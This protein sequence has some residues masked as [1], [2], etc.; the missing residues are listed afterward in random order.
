MPFKSEGGVFL[1]KRKGEGAALF[2]FNFIKLRLLKGGR[3]AFALPASRVLHLFIKNS[4]RCYVRGSLRLREYSSP[5]NG[6]KGQG[7]LAVA[8]GIARWECREAWASYSYLPGAPGVGPARLC[9]LKK[10]KSRTYPC[11]I[12]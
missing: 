1:F 11:S 8:V 10:V 12:Y 7:R 5:A 2:G 4:S 6:I 9:F 3:R